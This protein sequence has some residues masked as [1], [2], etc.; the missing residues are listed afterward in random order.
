MRWLLSAALASFAAMVL[1]FDFCCCYADGEPG[2]TSVTVH[3]AVPTEKASPLI[4]ESAYAE[5]SPMPSNKAQDVGSA[6]DSASPHFV[7]EA[8]KSRTFRVR[9]QSGEGKTLGLAFD[10]MDPDVCIVATVHEGGL[11]AKHNSKEGL[12]EDQ[13]IRQFDRLLGVNDSMVLNGNDLQ[14]KLKA[15]SGNSMELLFEHPEKSEFTMDRNGE[16]L[17][18]SLAAS[19]ASP[20]ICVKKLEPDGAMSKK[21]TT[22]GRLYL[23]P[24]DRIIEVNGKASDRAEMARALADNSI[25]MTVCSYYVPELTYRT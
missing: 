25:T 16:K 14:E 3:R 12:R 6:K 22:D 9:F 11:A 17:G 7:L 1:T 24:H 2:G 19:K 20:S 13:Q 18:I 8:A 15:S 10:M 5:A 23:K 21:N 4:L